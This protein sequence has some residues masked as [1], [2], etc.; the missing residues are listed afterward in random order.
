MATKQSRD[1]EARAG[2][3]SIPRRLLEG[4]LEV[5]P[6]RR[7]DATLALQDPWLTNAP[8]TKAASSYDAALAKSSASKESEEYLDTNLRG[9]SRFNLDSELTPSCRAVHMNEN[10]YYTP[11][12]PGKDEREEDFS[13]AEKTPTYLPNGR[14]SSRGVR[15]EARV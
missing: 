9:D 6:A 13:E 10:H 14:K 1:L 3:S 2:S 5:D 7:F 8:G 15:V 11:M 12:T 4:M